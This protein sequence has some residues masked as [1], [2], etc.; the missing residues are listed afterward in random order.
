MAGALPYRIALLAVGLTWLG[1][2]VAY[3]NGYYTEDS[4]GYVT[5]AIWA[6]LGEYH[7]RDNVN[8]L[9]V[10]T[11]LPVAVAIRFFGKSEIA[12]SVWPMF[13]SLLGL[14]SLGGLTGILFGRPYALLAAFLYATYPGDIFFSTVVMPDSLQAGWMSFS[15]FLVVLAFV[16]WE[17]KKR[18]IVIGGGVAMGCG[19]LM[20]A[21]DVLLVPVGL[22]AVAIFA[23]IC[24]RDGI[25]GIAGACLAY[26]S[27]WAL[28]VALEG[29]AYLYAA[30][31]FF[32]RFR[33]INGHYGSPGS[34]AAAGLNIEAATIPF[35]IFA[36]LTWWVRG[37]WGNLNQDQAYHALLFCW[38]L[39]ALL[40]GLIALKAN[41]KNLSGSALAAYG[42]AVLWVSW[43][44]LYHQFGSQSVSAFVPM[45]R[46]SRHLVVYAP[47]A[48]FA[49]VAGC[50][51]LLE[52]ADQRR[53]A[54]ARAALIVVGL[55][56]LL[57]HVRF[58]LMGE[59]IAYSAYHRI[60]GTYSRIRER[61]PPDVRTIVADPGDLSFFDFW[62]NPF[63]SERVRMVAFA[64]YAACDGLG[65]GVVLTRSNPGWELGA[66]VIQETVRRL[67]CLVDP[68][69][70]WRLVYEGYPERVY[71][72]GSRDFRL[73]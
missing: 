63:G 71:E 58:N 6:A 27:G 22:F 36:P 44:L 21:N 29:M 38:A 19:H 60:K 48:V 61:L 55:T 4:P 13:C 59:E 42:L 25:A 11:Y 53:M 5:D 62:L 41:W 1:L 54:R 50:F 20:R 30:D 26:L 37:D 12:L 68:P 17:G 45:H 28:I 3:W 35:S 18:W 64:R 43:P 34:I 7:A 9:N 2:R 31:D 49:I 72:I 16:R 14:V 65:R 47:G 73:E 56:I 51:L 70:D 8:G 10:G 32:L 33:V 24:A 69:A 23:A 15:I 39:G 40:A 52:W 57:V 46:L 66:P 67:P